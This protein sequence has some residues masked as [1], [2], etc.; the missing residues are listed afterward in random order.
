ME[1]NVRQLLLYGITIAL[2]C[3]LTACS[4]ETRLQGYIEGE[5][6]YLSSNYSGIL[7]QL[8]ITRGD[9]VK[10]G[11]LL[12]TLDREPEISE[13]QQAQNQLTQ[14]Q[15]ILADLIAKQRSSVLQGIIA[16][17]KQAAAD[18][19]YAKV[20]LQRNQQLF[21]KGATSKDAVD[22][23]Q[24]R[25]DRDLNLK[26]Q[27]DAN[28]AEALQGA[29]VHAIDA[30]QQAVAAA[31]ANV[32]KYTWMLAQKSL[33]APT[34]GRIFDTYF[35]VGEFVNSQQ[36]VA[37]LLAPQD[38]KLIFYIPEPQ[39]SQLYMGQV[40]YFHCD[41][42]RQREQARIYYIAP[43]AEYTPPVIFSEESRQKL[44]YRI[45]A[46]LPLATAKRF[47]PGQPVDVYIH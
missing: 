35:K 26:R 3:I 46:H 45:E 14:A 28:L 25:Y 31:A 30:Q 36:P 16:Q 41:G 27:Y 32:Q 13:L 19:A 38:I 9:L 44:V 29:R 22:Q 39:R 7:K 37:S 33:Y 6:I 15:Q 18:L 24:A 47:Y 12:F 4:R 23:A 21:Q 34:S 17:Q 20:T 5:Y 10:Q 8:L 43:Q 11:Q 1:R 40:V 42:C 2:V